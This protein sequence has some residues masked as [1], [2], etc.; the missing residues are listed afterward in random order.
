[1]IERMQ[2]RKTEKASL[3]SIS[4]AIGDLKKTTTKSI[5][6][7]AIF[8]KRGFD[9]TVSLETFNDFTHDMLAFKK[10]TETTLFNLDGH[11]RTTNER[12]DA[13]EK[14]LGPL[15]QTTSFYQQTLREHERRIA[16]L[17]RKT[18]LAHA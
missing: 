18:G 3:V 6:D 2:K 17:E 7:L 4:S 9:Q 10:H 15:V 12:L 11:A 5:S 1:M 8:T 14:A 13:I 16:F